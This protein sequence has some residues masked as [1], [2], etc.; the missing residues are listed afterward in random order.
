[1]KN[2][3]ESPPRE[4][5]ESMDGRP[6]K[7]RIGKWLI[8]KQNCRDDRSKSF[9]S[10]LL[11]RIQNQLQVDEQAEGF[12]IRLATQDGAVF[13]PGLSEGEPGLLIV[14]YSGYQTNDADWA[15]EIE[16]QTL[17]AENSVDLELLIEDL[18]AQRDGLLRMPYQ[19]RDSLWVYGRLQRVGATLLYILPYED[20]QMVADEA[21]QFIREAT[22]E[23]IQIAS[24]AS[25]ML[26]A[27]V[28]ALAVF[29]SRSV[30]GPLRD[31]SKMATHLAN[32]D[33]NAKVEVQGR[34]EIGDV[35]E[36]FNVMVPQLRENM[37][38]RQTMAT[39][40]EVQQNLLPKNAPVLEG[41][42]IAGRSLYCDDIGG[43]YYDFLNLPAAGFGPRVGIAVGDVTG[44]G[45]PSALTM[46]TVRALLHAKAHETLSL[47]SVIDDVNVHLTEGAT[48]GRFVTLIY[49]VIEPS[50]RTVRWVSAGHDPTIVFEPVSESFSELEGEDIPLGVKGDWHFKESQRDEWCDGAIMVIGTDGIW[51]ARNEEGEMF[52]KDSLRD[53][54]QR[55]AHRPAETICEAVSQALDAFRGTTQYKDD[56]TLV[57]IKFAPL[58]ETTKSSPA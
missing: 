32:G 46:T 8:R 31:L 44:H 50:T 3:A 35:A 17:M 40:Y 30:T 5:K 48:A 14:A 57:V 10:S 19:G 18:E 15:T 58:D 11:N 29:A 42:D 53:V 4:T 21:Q 25:I 16:S 52:G 1:M 51:E 24:V 12:I 9:F 45:V 33:L 20:I 37:N 47:A 28:G 41:L 49:M 55:H 34:D 6:R 27:L 2:S 13:I 23:Q 43:D 39:A 26:I 7:N 22:D 38:V 54:I 56:V 36:A